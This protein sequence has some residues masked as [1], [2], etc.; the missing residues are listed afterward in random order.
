MLCM[1]RRRVHVHDSQSDQTTK[2]NLRQM[3]AHHGC[4]MEEEGYSAFDP[5]GDLL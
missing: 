5:S 1:Q 2:T 3:A 4:S